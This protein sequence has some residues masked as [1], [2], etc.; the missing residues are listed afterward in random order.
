[1]SD[2]SI[3]TITILIADD[4]PLARAGIRTILSQIDD[5]E[6]IGEAQDGFEVQEL[7]PKFLPKILLLDY[8][9]PGPRAAEL[10]EWVRKNYPETT[11]L[12]L[13]A[14]DRDEYLAKMI[15]SG[16]AGFLL[17]S[18]NAEQLITAIRHAAEGTV[19]FSDEQTARAQEW[20]QTVEA[21]WESLSHRE[22]EILQH[23]ARGADNKTIAQILTITIKT[24]EFHVT[25]ILKKLNVKNR[26]EAIVWMLKH[27]PDNP[28]NKKD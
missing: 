12:I 8:Q 14:H 26:E 17:K 6:I 28:W 18:E 10:E 22:Q 9:M 4:E 15:N 7:V 5:L 23:L 2:K 1:M 13:T 25:N 24:V 11:V 20:K 3:K 27:L 21:K 19:Y 16:I